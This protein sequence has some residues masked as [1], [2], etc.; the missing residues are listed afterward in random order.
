LLDE[1]PQLDDDRI[2]CLLFLAF[3]V[4]GLSASIGR[5]V[6]VL[7]ISFGRSSSVLAAGGAREHV[8]PFRRAFRSD[9]MAGG[10]PTLATKVRAKSQGNSD[11][12]LKG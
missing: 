5:F 12:R 2:C 4:K 7:E 11:F 10:S 6:F 8:K 1:L 9:V 3:G